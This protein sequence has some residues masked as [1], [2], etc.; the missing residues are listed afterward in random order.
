MKNTISGIARGAARVGWLFGAASA[1]IGFAMVGVVVYGVVMRYIFRAPTAYSLEMPE[2]MFI[3]L[4]SLCLMY[5]QTQGSHVRVEVITVHLHGKVKN[6]FSIVAYLATLAYCGVVVWAMWNRVIWNM[7]RNIGSL[8]THIPM[9]PFS[10]LIM[11]G[12]ALL[13]VH[14]IIEL[15][16]LVTRGEQQSVPVRHSLG[17]N[18]VVE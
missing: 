7:S 2:V 9:A 1:L 5:A 13:A 16:R 15:V 11:L 10:F 12:I 3:T 14:V 8:Q 6:A 17:E 4:I 18:T